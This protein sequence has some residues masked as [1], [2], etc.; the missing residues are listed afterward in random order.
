MVGCE[1]H[2]QNTDQN[3]LSIMW[4][5]KVMQL[6]TSV[7]IRKCDHNKRAQHLH[8]LRFTVRPHHSGGIETDLL[9]WVAKLNSCEKTTPNSECDSNI[10]VI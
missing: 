4:W 10:E 7:I 6:S 2:N 9:F 5:E 1:L 8:A 3:K